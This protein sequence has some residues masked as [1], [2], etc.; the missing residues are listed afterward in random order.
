MKVVVNRYTNIKN[1][2]LILVALILSWFLSTET[3]QLFHSPLVDSATNPEI[4]SV[5][6]DIV[7]I[8]TLGFTAYELSKSTV[9]P[10][11]V[12]AIFFGFVSQNALSFITQNSQALSI[13][14]T[15]GAV[16]ILFG[17]GIETPFARFKNLI[18]PIISIAFLG[19]IITGIAFSLVLAGVNI[20]FNMS[21]PVSA[22][23]LLGIAL[24]ST[25]PA[26]IIPSFK[27]LLFHN[28]RVK[29]IAIS[30]S[31]LNDVV[32]ALIT[33]IFL[34]L[35][36]GNFTPTSIIDAYWNL[37]TL[38]NLFEILKVIVIGVVAG[39][40]G[41]FILHTWSKWKEKIESDGEADAALFLAVPLFTYTFAITLGGNGFL[42]VFIAGLV[43]Q[44]RDHI[45]HVEN[46]FNHTIEGFMK[47]LI[48]MLLGTLVNFQILQQYA[49]PGIIMAV[50]FMFVIRPLVVF[51]TLF[52]FMKGGHKLSFKELLFLSF[53][54]ET[55]VIPAV[56]L[57]SIKVAGIPGSD[58]AL[59]I[60]MWIILLTLIIQPPLTPYV[61]KLLGVADDMPLFPKQKQR[62]PLAVLCSRSYTWQQRIDLVVDWAQKNCVENISLLYCPEDKYNEKV[63][64]KVQEAATV[65]FKSVNA[66]L[67]SEN[68]KE[69][70]FCFICRPGTLESNIKSLVNENDVSIVFIGSKML[71][72]RMEIVKSLQVPFIFIE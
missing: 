29:H 46:F 16:L 65:R 7:I 61:A 67:R 31:A 33:G 25:D 57:V 39:A 20:V 17:G 37:L 15:I 12:I 68:K 13:L 41:Y 9:I 51:L 60:G 52:P 62:G 48:F 55:G 3:M 24:A 59:A 5:F 36:V 28:P 19:T 6:L 1:Y 49:V 8:F 40:I 50:V 54:R 45:K 58:I 71:D 32:G 27:S 21:M 30:E 69:L 64:M 26:A 72:Y 38:E 53:V 23:I 10:S 4:L 63:L 14:T 47:P 22:I 43:F 2:G 56:L 34:V 70:N 11:F 35:F 18:G 42:A 44:L 66:K